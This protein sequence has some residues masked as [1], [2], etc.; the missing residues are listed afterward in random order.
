MLVRGLLLWGERLEVVRLCQDN[1][2]QWTAKKF[3]RIC[4]K[5]VHFVKDFFWGL[6]L[7]PNFKLIWSPL[8]T[9]YAFNFELY[10]WLKNLKDLGHLKRRNKRVLSFFQQVF[11]LLPTE[12]FISMCV[13]PLWIIISYQVVHLTEQLTTYI[14]QNTHSCQLLQNRLFMI[15]LNH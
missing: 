15:K 3:C 11:F 6:Y 10:P 9:L 14:L 8:F 12:G 2:F 5:Q 7:V 13:I 1:K 4:F